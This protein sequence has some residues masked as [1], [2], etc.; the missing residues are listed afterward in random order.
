MSDS[1]EHHESKH[2]SFWS[3]TKRNMSRAT[4]KAKLRFGKSDASDS[5]WKEE[6]DRFKAHKRAVQHINQDSARFLMKMKDMIDAR[7]SMVDQIVSIFTPE[8]AL[9][10]TALEYQETTKK[11][12]QARA[13]LDEQLKQEFITPTGNYLSQFED[14]KHRL[15]TV[16]ARR[17]EMERRQHNL[18]AAQK[19]KDS[20]KISAAELKYNTAQASYQTL[21]DEVMEDM[22]VL[23]LD[24]VRF[25]G[26]ALAT[27]AHAEAAAY[28]AMA[29][30]VEDT[31]SMVS[32]VDRAEITQTQVIR[33]SVRSTPDSAPTPFNSQQ[34]TN[35]NADSLSASSASFM[36][37]WATLDEVSA[38]LE[39]SLVGRESP[40]LSYEQVEGDNV[41][42]LPAAPDAGTRLS[43]SQ[44]RFLLSLSSTAPVPAI[45]IESEVTPLLESE[46]Q[47]AGSVSS[48]S[49]NAVDNTDLIKFSTS[50]VGGAE[51][52]GVAVQ[53]ANRDLITM[54]SPSQA[55]PAELESIRISTMTGSE[56]LV[57]ASNVPPVQP[58][59]PAEGGVVPFFSAVPS[60]PGDLSFSSQVGRAGTSSLAPPTLSFS[61]Q[62]T[63]PS[64]SNTSSP[65]P[66]RPAGGLAVYDAPFDPAEARSLLHAQ[67]SSDLDDD[68]ARKPHLPTHTAAAPE[69]PGD[70]VPYLAMKFEQRETV[71]VPA[72]SDFLGGL[73]GPTPSE[74]STASAVP[75]GH[76]VPDGNGGWALSMS[77]S[78]ETVRPWYSAVA[79]STPITSSE[80]EHIKP[81][82]LGWAVDTNAEALTQPWFLNRSGSSPVAA[83]DNLLTKPAQSADLRGSQQAM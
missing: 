36:P 68:V 80:T 22:K 49:A 83:E 79:G 57:H 61:A 16:D 66:E 48:S 43:A 44:E 64:L 42:A 45:A 70:S 54:S 7:R 13:T 59:H 39:A 9:Y 28:E 41:P 73:S 35:L 65:L 29:S 6:T 52:L 78:S 25:F 2:G 60:A 11:L 5:H 77:P 3:K 24:R 58:I 76:I 50:Q 37:A 67:A 17:G 51:A 56:P 23:W 34:V 30:S 20:M 75:D 14:L 55:A 21:C 27:L 19:T 26:A 47:S 1:H 62:V 40:G 53:D 71:Q 63:G 10:N 15:R 82:D 32:H 72:A 81:S 46:H 4:Q 33:S 12:D 69:A 74:L 31:L 18:H 38:S 8:D